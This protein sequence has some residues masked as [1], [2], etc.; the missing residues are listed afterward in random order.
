MAVFSQQGFSKIEIISN[1]TGKYLQGNRDA[2]NTHVCFQII[3]S[4]GKIYFLDTRPTQFG[5]RWIKSD[6]L[7]RA[8]SYGKLKEKKH[9]KKLQLVL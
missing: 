1:S 6:I 4:N 5:Y 3:E 8:A 2:Y 7:E 9:I